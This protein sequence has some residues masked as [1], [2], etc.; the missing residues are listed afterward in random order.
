M[1]ELKPCPFC[2]A[3]DGDAVLTTYEDSDENVE[4]C[5]RC[6][7]CG[8]YLVHETECGNETLLKIRNTRAAP[9]MKAWE[10]VA[11][12]GGACFTCDKRKSHVQLN[13]H[14][15]WASQNGGQ[16]IMN[17][18]KP[19]YF[20]TDREAMDACFNAVEQELKEWLV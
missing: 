11:V 6:Y 2:G 19:K 14:G 1:S 13:R 12:N 3:L 20:A 16:V 9:T 7:R 17:G 10:W 8:F 15:W 5:I 18:D 4:A